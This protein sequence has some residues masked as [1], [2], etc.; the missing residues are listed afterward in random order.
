[1][2]D[3]DLQKLFRAKFAPLQPG[4]APGVAVSIDR[5]CASYFD[6]AIASAPIVPLLDV[7]PSVIEHWRQSGL[8]EL[9]ALEP[10][11]R[12]M[13]KGLRVPDSQDQAV[14]DFIYAMY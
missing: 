8:Q 7:V 3:A 6:D 10:E 4:I 11:L 13:E 5:N 9:V 12:R 2:T 14:P 1:L